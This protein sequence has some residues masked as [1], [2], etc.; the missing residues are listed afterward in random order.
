YA[1]AGG[2]PAPVPQWAGAETGIRFHTLRRDNHLRDGRDP[3]AGGYDSGVLS[4]VTAALLG[5]PA[6]Q[7]YAE[8]GEF[9]VEQ[10]IFRVLAGQFG[11]QGFG[12]SWALFAEVRDG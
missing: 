10:R 7:L 5:L 11:E 6:L 4:E 2:E 12:H 8:L 3:A 1:L 9:L